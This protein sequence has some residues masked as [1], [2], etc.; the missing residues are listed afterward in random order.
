VRS[1]DNYIYGCAAVWLVRPLPLLL[2]SPDS[3]ATQFATVSNAI[4]H[5]NLRSLRPAGS[6]TR[7]IPRGYGFDIVSC[8]N[9]LFE[10]IAWTSFTTLTLD[11]AGSSP[12]LSRPY[13][14]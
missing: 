2:L 13:V 8:P 10:A 7:A 5:L 3:L 12:P 4:T 1:T 11:W 14:N 6:K 9:Y